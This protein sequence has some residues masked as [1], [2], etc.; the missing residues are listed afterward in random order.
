M[1]QSDGRTEIT[2]STSQDCVCESWAGMQEA[3]QP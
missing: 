3:L 2:E 1:L